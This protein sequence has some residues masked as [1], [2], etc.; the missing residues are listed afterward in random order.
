[1]LQTI[2]LSLF[3]AL[4]FAPATAQQPQPS[5]VN[6][7]DATWINVVP[8]TAGFTVLMPGKPAEQAQAVEG[9]PGVENHML[10]LETRLAGYVV[11]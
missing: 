9:H 5:P 11:S 7:A 3:I 2:F 10:T 4:S 6:T 1:M 8:A